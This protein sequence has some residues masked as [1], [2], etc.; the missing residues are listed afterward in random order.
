MLVALQVSIT[1]FAGF[2]RPTRS[3]NVLLI[4]PGQPRPHLALGQPEQGRPYSAGQNRRRE[5]LF[6]AVD[7]RAI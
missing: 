5:K 2:L 1:N 4:K 7:D 3:S 6:Y